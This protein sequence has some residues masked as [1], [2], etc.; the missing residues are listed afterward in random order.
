[1]TIAMYER[2]LFGL[3]SYLFLFAHPDDDL[4]CCILLKRLIEEKKRVHALYLT[5]G[6]AG[7]RSGEREAE[8]FCALERTG[9]ERENVRFLR[10]P[11]IELAGSLNRAV[12]SAVHTVRTCGTDCIVGHDYEGGHEAH[13]L[14]SF[15]ASETGKIGRVGERFVFPVYHGPPHNR[16]GARFIAGRKAHVTI[17]FEKG[18]K[19]LKE[20]ALSCYR[21]QR[22][23]F[24]G[25]GRSCS[26]YFELLFSRELYHRICE[27]I[28]YSKKPT[29][30]VG[31]EY[32]RNGFTFELFR[33]V[34]DAY[35]KRSATTD[36]R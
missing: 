12:S 31:Y 27:P 34:L 33:R 1:M 24:D 25:L 9:I 35:K 26:D 36:P 8:V 13:D 17:S 16:T 3:R 15:C 14:A 30:V 20:K 22:E 10:I 7:G 28:D 19:K 5:S 4:Y 6:D 2:T 32:H 21:S 23:H 29:D 18:D 11:E